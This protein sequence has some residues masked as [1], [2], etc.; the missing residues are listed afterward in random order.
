MASGRQKPAE[1]K[2]EVVATDKDA[3]YRGGRCLDLGPYI[4][5]VV[6][7]INALWVRDVGHDLTHMEGVGWIPPQGGLQADGETTSER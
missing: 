4:L 2:A 5:G 3:E 1:G 6:P 7:V